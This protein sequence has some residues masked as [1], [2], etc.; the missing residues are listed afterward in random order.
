L[1][2]LFN[3][4]TDNFESLEPTLKDRFDLKDQMAD[5]SSAT[6]MAIDESLKAFTA[7]QN[8]GGTMSYKKFIASGNEGVSKFFKDGGRVN[9]NSGTDATSFMSPNMKY[10]LTGESD[11]FRIQPPLGMAVPLGGLYLKKKLDESKGKKIKPS[12]KEPE[13]PQLPPRL[14]IDLFADF[15]FGEALKQKKPKVK[16]ISTKQQK[17]PLPKDFTELL[18]DQKKAAMKIAEMYRDREFNNPNLYKLFK[19]YTLKFHSGNSISAAKDFPFVKELNEKLQQR[20]SDRGFKISFGYGPGKRTPI[21]EVDD[22]PFRADSQLTDYIQKNPNYLQDRIKKLKQFDKKGFYT[23]TQIAE[24]LGISNDPYAHTRLIRFVKPY[25]IRTGTPYSNKAV[26][27]KPGTYAKSPLYNLEDVVRNIEAFSKNKPDKDRIRSNASKL[28]KIA[29]ANFDEGLYGFT[30]DS[31][32]QTTGKQKQTF[33]KD[34][35]EELETNEISELL[36]HSINYNIGHQV[37]VSFMSEKGFQLPIAT[38]PENMDKLYGL[39]TLVFQDAKINYELGNIQG[40]DTTLMKT[41]N[42]FLEDNQGKT[43]DKELFKTIKK[44]NEESKNVQKF[45]QDRVKEFL[46]EV[47]TIGNKK[48]KRLVH[49]PYLKDQDKTIAKVILDLKPGDTVELTSIDV[50][51]SDVPNRLRFGKINN[52]NSKANKIKDLSKEELTKYEK[53]ISSQI[54]DYYKYVTGAAG[55]EGVIEDEEFNEVAEIENMINDK[56][57]FGT[58][59][60]AD[61]APE[62]DKSILR[63][64]FERFTKE[65][66]AEGGRVGF[67]DGTSNPIF[68]QI[69]A[70]LD[71]TDLIENLEQENKRTLEE[72]ILGEEGDRTLMQT[73]NTMIDPR[74]F[75]YYA[76][77]LASGV[78]N[79]PELAFRFPAALAYLFGKTS[80]ATTTGDLSQI[81][82]KDVQKAM[83]IMDP[84]LT[85][86]VKEKIG[87]KDML[88]ESREKATG[89]QRTTGGL[90]EF[91]AEAVGPATPFFLLKAFPKIGKQI[92]NLVGTA[93][94]AEKVNKEIETKM[95]TQGVDQT[96][97]DILLAAGAGGAVAILKYLGLDKLIKTTKVAKAAPE[98]ITKGGTPKYFFDFVN[99]IKTKGDDVTDKASTIERQKVYDYDGYTLYE[100]IGSGKIAIRKDT[101]GGANYYVGD[102]EYETIDGILYK[103]EIVYDPPETIVGKDGKAKEVPDIYEETTLKPDYDGSDGDVEGGLESINEILELLA[104][105]GNKYSLKELK[106]MGMNPEGL[107]RDFLEKILKNPDEIKLL[108]SE[109][110]FKDTINKVKYKIE[111]AE[112]GIIAGVSSGPPP[113]SGPTPHGLPYVA[114]NVRPITERK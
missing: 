110:A 18:D 16:N 47:Y 108:D 3:P 90:L 83:E 41:I 69:V 91:G 64:L 11:E 40:K 13:P 53:N 32:T 114:K 50:D 84:K 48:A 27:S 42:D 74:A 1:K 67:Q 36:N 45:K 92:R 103:E 62:P 25:K 37:P 97:R 38:I 105:D 20:A 112:G 6:Q 86:A 93:A 4:A 107:G 96:R 30:K 24:I 22:Q 44:I 2:Y 65:N 15:I 12:D 106:E 31:I 94:S 55:L 87:F 58:V 95:A 101:S 21:I 46:N 56:F 49:E 5:A 72:Q 75:P 82:M 79:I 73:L 109:K 34:L 10:K 8:A 35:E 63:G 14:P 98:I 7:Y 104:K 102:G 70:A 71:N 60:T 77:E 78:A 99:L 85:K 80:L 100:D 54:K 33:F 113:K 26:K 61:K 111:K 88:E 43:V 66:M 57:G 81:G 19:E 51:M 59:T 23:L 89:P 68:D 17:E 9:F 39:N 28:R 29:L 52:V 76:Q